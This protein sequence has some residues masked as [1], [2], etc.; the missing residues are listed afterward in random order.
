MSSISL[1]GFGSRSRS[2]A[3][4]CC[5][6]VYITCMGVLFLSSPIAFVKI[7]EFR[8]C[9]TVY[10][11]FTRKGGKTGRSIYH[12]TSHEGAVMRGWIHIQTSDHRPHIRSGLW[13]KILE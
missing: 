6:P 5:P 10:H 2:I 12:F 7:P 13:T 1:P 11:S 3:L 8:V 9:M 4:A